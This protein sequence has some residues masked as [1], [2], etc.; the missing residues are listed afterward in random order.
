MGCSPDGVVSCKCKTGSHAQKWA[1]EIK[2]PHK[3]ASKSPKEAALQRG[4]VVS[5]DGSW[6]L[7]ATHHFYYQIQGQLG[8]LGLD[9]CDLV[10]FT[11]K[12][13]HVVQVPFD[14]DFYD[15]MCSR[16]NMFCS[17]YLFVSLI[18]H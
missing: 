16:V 2:C 4:C 15:N 9:H 6:R 5:S 12:G 13:L 10:Y 14:K 18:S 1:L 7:E 3:L 11:K 8:I 17:E